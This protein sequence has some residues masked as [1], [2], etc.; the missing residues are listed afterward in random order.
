MIHPYYTTSFV[1][2]E[3]FAYNANYQK[4][5][6]EKKTAKQKLEAHLA[7]PETRIGYAFAFL[8]DFGDEEES[9]V[10]C[11]NKIAEWSDKLDTS[12][13]HF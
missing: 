5:Q 13:A 2:R 11:Y 1:D 7:Q 8:N 6:E 12:E 4:Q 9:R 10:K 3:M